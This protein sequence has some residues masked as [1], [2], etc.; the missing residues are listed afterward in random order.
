MSKP[1]RFRIK[2]HVSNSWLDGE[3]AEQAAVIQHMMKHY[4]AIPVYGNA[5]ANIYTGGWGAGKQH[6]EE[7]NAAYIDRCKREGAKAGAQAFKIKQSQDLG[8]SSYWPDLTIARESC[9]EFKEAFALPCRPRCLFIEMKQTDGAVY[10]KR[11]HGL[12][13]NERLQGQA[14]ILAQLNANGNFGSF[15]LGHLEATMLIDAYFAGKGLDQLEV[16]PY[17]IPSGNIW[18]IK[19]KDAKPF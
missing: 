2:G 6:P 16:L 17:A 4:P 5:T 9:K 14:A 10:M 19:V 8:A 3:D 12:Y 1:P 13:A 11:E 15:A 18:R 7:S